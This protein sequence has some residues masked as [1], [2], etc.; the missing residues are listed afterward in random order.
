MAKGDWGDINLWE[1]ITATLTAGG[2][3]MIRF[4]MLLRKGRKLRWFDFLLEPCLAIF[5]GMLVWG[6]SEMVHTP[7]L[8]QLVLSN[9]GAWG[10]PKTIQA[11]E[12]KYLGPMS[13]E[14]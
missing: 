11:L 3:G 9:L 2:V 10:G 7:D 4:L 6:L 13:K 1:V 14:P 12:V 8:M 5:A